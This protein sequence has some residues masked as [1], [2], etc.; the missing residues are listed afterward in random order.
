MCTCPGR[1]DRIAR[2]R[3]KPLARL[4]APALGFLR[5]AVAVVVLS[6]AAYVLSWQI[7]YDGPLGNDAPYHLH[8]A[9]WIDSSFPAVHCGTGGTTMASLTARVTR[10]PL[11]GSLSRSPE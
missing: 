11:I 6:A 8:L 9:Q 5:L 7:L 4:R 3:A 10:W 1:A 2:R